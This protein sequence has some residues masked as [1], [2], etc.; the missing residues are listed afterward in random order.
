MSFGDSLKKGGDEGSAPIHITI[1]GAAADVVQRVDHASG[2]QPDFQ[3][4]SSSEVSKSCTQLKVSPTSSPEECSTESRGIP[5]T[6]AA[7]PV[8][9]GH[10]SRQLSF[11]ANPP[12][13]APPMNAPDLPAALHKRAASQSFPS[14]QTNSG[15]SPQWL[16][17]S[18]QMQAER[19]QSEV[20]MWNCITPVLDVLP[21]GRPSLYPWALFMIGFGESFLLR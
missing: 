10:E 9:H 20:S 11:T 8:V 3:Y 13:S 6:S 7:S 21:D 2:T 19:T 1:D 12:S 17:E 4:E 5:L 18:G 14:P 15:S 16:M